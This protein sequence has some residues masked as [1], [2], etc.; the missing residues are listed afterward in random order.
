MGGFWDLFQPRRWVLNELNHL[1][2]IENEDDQSMDNYWIRKD[3]EKKLLNDGIIEERRV[4]DIPGF[5]GSA[6]LYDIQGRTK[7]KVPLLIR[8]SD[9]LTKYPNSYHIAQL[10]AVCATLGIQVGYL[11][12]FSS[13]QQAGILRKVKFDKL[14][15]ARAA[16]VTQIGKM[17]KLPQ[18]EE[19]C[20]SLPS[21]PDFMIKQHC[22]QNCICK[23][24]QRDTTRN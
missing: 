12:N 6:L 24:E 1:E 2:Y 13:M 7:E 4:A 18:G 3:I 17:I 8:V 11:F 20:T 9:N 16:F 19:L 15:K 22:H 23:A 14:S 21:C 10:G 5:S